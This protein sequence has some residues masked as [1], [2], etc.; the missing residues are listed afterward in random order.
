MQITINL[1]HM[2]NYNSSQ[3][4]QPNIPSSTSGNIK[5]YSYFISLIVAV[6]V[7][8]LI[9]GQFTFQFNKYDSDR[10]KAVFLTNGQV[11]FGKIKDE[12]SDPVIITDIYYLR[13]S[14][15]L[16][17]ISAGEELIKFDKPEISLVK[18]GNEL[19][20]PEDEMRINRQ[21]ILFIETL[22]PDSKVVTAIK[23]FK[24]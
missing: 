20:G 10:W 18:L 16:Q 11:Y 22:K 9:I 3:P 19:H 12:T 21:H 17:Q 14:R 15:P 1:I 7:L 23:N 4:Q 13:V 2:Q 5:K 8:V 6:I 24:N